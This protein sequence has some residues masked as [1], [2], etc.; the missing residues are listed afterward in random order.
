MDFYT[1]LENVSC[2]LDQVTKVRNR[3]TFDVNAIINKIIVDNKLTTINKY[4]DTIHFSNDVTDTYQLD[5]LFLDRKQKVSL[6]SLGEDKLKEMIGTSKDTLYNK[7]G[8]MFYGKTAMRFMSYGYTE[9]QLLTMGICEMVK[10]D[11]TEASN[12]ILGPC[13][14]NVTRYIAVDDEDEG[15]LDY[16]SGLLNDLF[17]TIEKE[18]SKYKDYTDYVYDITCYQSE[19]IITQRGTIYEYKIEQITTKR[20]TD[21]ELRRDSPP[22]H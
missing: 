4:G 14:Y 5:S 19:I 22:P 10:H 3:V 1:A 8:E 9:T 2:S 7:S 20:E 12:L 18:L 13:I 6:A 11:F 16:L 15:T 21:K 17:V